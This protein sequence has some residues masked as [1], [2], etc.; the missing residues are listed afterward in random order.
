M[1][2]APCTKS[3]NKRMAVFVFP[4]TG[5]EGATTLGFLSH[6]L[7]L[8]QGRGQAQTHA[9]LHTYV[10][11]ACNWNNKSFGPCLSPTPTPCPPCRVGTPGT[12]GALPPGCAFTNALSQRLPPTGAAL[13]PRCPRLPAATPALLCNATE[14][15]P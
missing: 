13:V 3:T 9:E 8:T 11:G 4:C 6:P 15:H 5:G 10:E 14:V 7:H 2:G 12:P 1:E